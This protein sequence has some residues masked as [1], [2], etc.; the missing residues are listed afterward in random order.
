M[1]ADTTLIWANSVV[2][3]Y[4]VAD[5]YMD[6]TC[7]VD[8]RY[9]EGDDTIWL[10]EALNDASLFELGVLV[11]D[12]FDREEDFLH[13]LEEFLFTRVLRFKGSENLSR[14]HNSFFL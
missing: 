10:Y 12:L 14:F 9:S 11:V 2:E 5:V 13:G 7:I 4:A 3:L 6:F 1:E 8:P